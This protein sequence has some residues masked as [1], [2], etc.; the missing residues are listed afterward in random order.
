ML[1]LLAIHAA[2]YDVL[3]MNVFQNG[4]CTG[5]Q[6]TINLTD[7]A[8]CGPLR[9]FRSFMLNRSMTEVEQLDF[10][11]NTS[12]NFA[13]DSLDHCVGFLQ[14]IWN[15]DTSCRSVNAST[16]VTLWTNTGPSD[17]SFGVG[18]GW[19]GTTWVNMTGNG[20][21]RQKLPLSPLIEF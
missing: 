20:I 6:E 18:W 19:N 16:C 3:H 15:W 14:S 4:D 10:S 21:I 11:A 5:N 12:G 7:I 8:G 9:P 13:L 1:S 17:D 2:A